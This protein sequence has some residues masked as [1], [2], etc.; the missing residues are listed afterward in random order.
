MRTHVAAI[1]G[2]IV[3]FA[4]MSSLTLWHQKPA[5]LDRTAGRDTLQ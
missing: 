3:Y 1:I 4:Q 2:T 5:R